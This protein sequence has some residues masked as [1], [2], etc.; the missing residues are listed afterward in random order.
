MPR[1]AASSA[2]R[3]R[4]SAK[5]GF[6]E[7]P[8]LIS[9]EEKRELIR[10]HAAARAPQDPLQR[11]SL[12]AGVTLSVLGIAIGWWL[13]VGQ[14]VR[15]TAD[16]TNEELH[17]VTQELNDFAD[18]VDAKALPFMQPPTPEA[19]AGS[20]EDMLRANLGHAS[21]TRELLSASPAPTSTSETPQQPS[22]PSTAPTIPPGLTPDPE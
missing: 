7:T 14:S 21:R 22:E 20:F 15:H 17:R 1:K 8:R 3:R 6:A 9:E 18:K 2:P 4:A 19:S 10:V 12:W 13:T 11:M 16:Q 5:A